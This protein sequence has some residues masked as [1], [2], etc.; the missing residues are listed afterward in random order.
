MGVAKPPTKLV[1]R[2]HFG[3]ILS[4]VLDKVLSAEPAWVELAKELNKLLQVCL[5]LRRGCLRVGGGDGV[6]K[7]PA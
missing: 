5:L 6:E 2:A 3:L 1:L 4:R 7:C